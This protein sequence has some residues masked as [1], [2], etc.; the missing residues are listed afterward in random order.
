M[1]NKKRLFEIMSKIDKTFILKENYQSHETKEV[2][3]DYF[4][5]ND[6]D[7]DEIIN[8][9]LDEFTEELQTPRTFLFQ[10]GDEKFISTDYNGKKYYLY[11]RI[12]H[13]GFEGEGDD[14]YCYEV[15]RVKVY[16]EGG[17][18]KNQLDKNYFIMV[19]VDEPYKRCHSFMNIH[20]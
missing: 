11:I 20:I 19:H 2:E 16:L 6:S 9:A 5:L 17:D 14:I 3:P 4:G 10:S 18:N 1:D 15:D 7:V 12:S 8:K 13:T